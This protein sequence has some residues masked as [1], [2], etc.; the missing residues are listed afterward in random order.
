[1]KC[2]LKWQKLVCLW[3]RRHQKEH[4]PDIWLIPPF[5]IGFV[6]P[7]SESLHNTDPYTTNLSRGIWKA[8]FFFPHQKKK[9]PI[10]IYWDFGP[11][12]KASPKARGLIPKLASC[13]LMW[14]HVFFILF[15]NFFFFSSVWNTKCFR[16]SLQ[17]TQS[18][19]PV[20]GK[21]VFCL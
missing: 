3:E 8:A 2:S 1:M 17:P 13:L 14:R 18:T 7:L 12:S 20:L 11:L 4:F 19:G 21:L 9:Y 16:P 10:K 6:K 5:L 15:T